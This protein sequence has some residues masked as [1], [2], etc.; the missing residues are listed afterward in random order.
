VV[1]TFIAAAGAAE[2]SPTAGGGAACAIASGGICA[3]PTGA[4]LVGEAG[5]VVAGS[6]QAGYGT[7]VIAYS[8]NKP[9][10][11][12]PQKMNPSESKIWE[13]FDNFKGKT[14]T[15]GTGKNQQFYQWDYTHGDIEVYDRNGNHLGSMD[16]KTGK[17]YKDPVPGR[18]LK[19]D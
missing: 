1:G 16:P 8:K 3:V 11:S 10:S 4:A 6:I 9:V 12:R 13:G 5:M 17:M 18:K 7:G 19:N 14:K 2:I 15:S